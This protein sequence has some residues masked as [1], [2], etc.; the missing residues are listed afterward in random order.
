MKKAIKLFG[1]IALLA[2]IGFSLAGCEDDEPCGNCN[3]TGVCQYC[4]GNGSYPVG[5]GQ[6]RC[7][8][9]KGTG[10]C[11]PC[12]GTGRKGKGAPASWG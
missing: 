3:G 10:R 6:T 4:D 9:C 7:S 11:P 2:V 12:D 1:I 8:L 5:G